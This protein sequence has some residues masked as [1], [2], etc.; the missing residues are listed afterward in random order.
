MS[1]PFPEM[2]RERVSL[3]VP[4]FMLFQYLFSE[5]ILVLRFSLFRLSGYRLHHER[6]LPVIR[7]VVREEDPGPGRQVRTDEMRVL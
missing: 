3:P 4:M 6:F 1:E 5:T 7:D 2:V